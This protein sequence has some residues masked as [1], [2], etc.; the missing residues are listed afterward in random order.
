MRFRSLRKARFDQL[1]DLCIG[2]DILIFRFESC[3][4]FRKDWISQN[5]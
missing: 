1:R 3:K 5:K 4:G 2:N